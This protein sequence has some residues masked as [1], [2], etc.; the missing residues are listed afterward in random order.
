VP[1]RI[2]KSYCRRENRQVYDTEIAEV[3]GTTA[4]VHVVNPTTGHTLD[5]WPATFK[6]ARVGT[7]WEI[8]NVVIES[9]KEPPPLLRF[10][11]P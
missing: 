9:P 5:N 4:R 7:T 10:P 8:T 11:T 2:T 6:G 3:P 1:K